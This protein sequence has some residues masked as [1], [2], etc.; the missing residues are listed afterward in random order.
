[1]SYLMEQVKVQIAQQDVESALGSLISSL[2]SGE[3]SLYDQALALSR[4]CKRFG[5]GRTSKQ[6]E[7][8]KQ[9]TRQLDSFLESLEQQHQPMLSFIECIKAADEHFEQGEWFKAQHQYRQANQLHQ[10]DF[11]LTE[12]VISHKIELCQLALQ[13]TYHL[14]LG[15]ECMEQQVWNKA[16]SHFTQAN[17]Y[18]HEQLPFSREELELKIEWIQQILTFEHHLVK[19]QGLQSQRN[20]EQAAFSFQYA[21]SLHQ[22]GF[23]PNREWLERTIGECQAQAKASSNRLLSRIKNLWQGSNLQPLWWGGALVAL[24]LFFWFSQSSVDLGSPSPV[25]KES[26]VSPQSRAVVVDAN[27]KT[28]IPNND[29]AKAKVPVSESID[30]QA[31]NPATEEIPVAPVLSPPSQVSTLDQVDDLL[32]ERQIWAEIDEDMRANQQN[33]HSSEI[34]SEAE[35]KSSVV[36]QQNA[37]FESADKKEA[38]TTESTVDVFQKIAVLPFCDGINDPKT[39]KR[40]YLDASFSVSNHGSEAWKAISKHSVKGTMKQLGLNHTQSCSKLHN[41]SIGRALQAD[42]LL[43]GNVEMMED[44]ILVHCQILQ[45]N[46][47]QYSKEITVAD[48]DLNTLR[49]KLKHEL[50]K[51]VDQSL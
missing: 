41:A 7:A 26:Q 35:Q 5:Q 9:T 23:S 17:A 33:N 51:L 21:L 15:A 25:D 38:I 49:E 45:P 10:P 13:Y 42:Y 34:V 44:K 40:L 50:P 22:E 2:K 46:T 47:G 43:T 14:D 11:Q 39:I 29:M 19:A 4:K 37:E 27:Q 6:K 16:L 1:M 12:D 32:K 3:K 20:W 30:D 28:P 48:K 24:V 18:L 31:P 8:I 36:P